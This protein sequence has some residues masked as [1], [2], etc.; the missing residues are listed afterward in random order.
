MV[1]AKIQRSAADGRRLGSYV[2][3][4][5]KE[6]LL[7]G[8]WQAGESIGVEA[9]KTELGVS[10][11][12]VMEALRRLAGDE[13][14]EIIPQVG[15][16]VPVYGPD[17]VSDFFTLF[18]SLEAEAAAVA[19]TRRSDSQLARLVSINAQ[20]GSLA[21]MPDPKERVHL[22]RTL[23]REFHTVI[24][25]MAHSAVVMRT[26]SRMWDMSDLLINAVGPTHPLANEVDQRHADHVHLIDALRRKD[27]SAARTHMRAHI[28]RNIA[29][30]EQETPADGEVSQG[31]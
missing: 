16:R 8:H 11:Q 22:Y 14:V 18:A 29:M 3:D 24:L 15:C 27:A 21:A 20:I 6:R 26:S 23:N 12:P 28:L 30:L 5:V 17:E 10:K 7:E 2:Y 19:A 4:V 13:L 9:L 25:E 1:G 31:A